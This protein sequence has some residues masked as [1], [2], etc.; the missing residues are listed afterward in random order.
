MI[1][2]ATDSRYV[3]GA[4]IPALGFSPIKNHPILLHDHNERIHENSILE[5]RLIYEKLISALTNTE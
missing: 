5:G 2:A 4:G 3:R 1:I